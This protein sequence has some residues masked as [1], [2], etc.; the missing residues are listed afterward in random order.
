MVS[1]VCDV[2]TGFHVEDWEQ[3]I[4]VLEGLRGGGISCLWDH[5]PHHPSQG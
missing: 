3:D 5:L 4:M 2:V 1:G